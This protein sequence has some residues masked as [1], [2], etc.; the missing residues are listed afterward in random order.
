MPLLGEIPPF[1]KWEPSYLVS[2]ADLTS[3]IPFEGLFFNADDYQRAGKYLPFVPEGGCPAG[4]RVFTK[5]KPF[6]Q[7]VGSTNAWDD[8]GCIATDIS[9]DP[10]TWGEGSCPPGTVEYAT[11]AR[12]P[13]E[14]GKVIKGHPPR[15]PGDI[16]EPDMMSH[17]F[18]ACKTPAQLCSDS[19]PAPS[20]LLTYPLCKDTNVSWVTGKKEDCGPGDVDL[21]RAETNPCPQG[22]YQLTDNKEGNFFVCRET[23]ETHAMRVAAWRTGCPSATVSDSPPKPLEEVSSPAD[24]PDDIREHFVPEPVDRSQKVEIFGL[25]LSPMSVV[26]I[27]A[28]LTYLLIGGQR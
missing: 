19:I 8:K 10:P 20:T 7:P 24:L 17:D 16:P 11:W 26:A 18:R 23:P 4:M 28:A 14:I 6:Y 27:G 22:F 13:F 21:P 1:F 9:H 15:F 25:K 5:H 12:I 2:P 3:G